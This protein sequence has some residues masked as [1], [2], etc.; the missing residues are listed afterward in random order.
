MVAPA[1]LVRASTKFLETWLVKRD[2]DKALGYISAQ[3]TD[4][5]KLNL[6]A[7]QPLPKTAEDT[8][9][10]LKK[11]MQHV[12]ET[13]GTVKRL[14]EAVVAPQPNHADIKLVKHGNSRAFA[15]VS[16]PDYRAP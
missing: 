3:C 10:Q 5:V 11:A 16:I 9:A 14:D 15:L 12:I 1:E 7:D 13:S 8:L 4:C 2:V 6:S